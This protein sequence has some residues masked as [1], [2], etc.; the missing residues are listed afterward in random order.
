MS[1]D[2]SAV[3]WVAT[4]TALVVL[5]AV[6]LL[7]V[8]R[9]RGAVTAGGAGICIAI[10]S[11]LA[12]LAAL[13]MAMVLGQGTAGQFLACYVT[14][15]SLSADNLFVFMLVISRFSVP[16]GAVDYV[17]SIGIA[18]SLV[19][20]TAFIVAG[21][22]A[23]NAFDWVFYLFGGF[24]VYTAIRLLL[25]ARRGGAD[26]EDSEEMPPGVSLLARIL[27]TSQVYD[28]RRLTV[29]I[30]GRRMLTPILLVVSV[31]GVA[32]VVFALDSLPA[33]FG[34]TRSPFVI[35]TA[36]AFAMLGLRQLYYVVAGLLTRL[37][38]LPA[39]L[40][41]I[42]GFIGVKLIFEA[43]HGS[44]VDRV[45]PVP[46]PAIGVAVSLAVIVGTLLAATVASM[47][48][49]RIERGRAEPDGRV[50]SRAGTSPGE[51]QQESP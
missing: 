24:L 5:L 18:L 38:Y 11:G 20:R 26:G 12:L 42:L 51:E 9:R 17:L 47:V 33:A 16:A 14:E 8:S 25:P 45:G 6:D 15:Y 34:L 1:T 23:A 28:G 39:A 13:A 2:V 22:A 31:I 44:H 7:V 43:L 37:V 3:G 29:T 27:P 36:N 4:V 35:I 50:T 10:Y 41:V 32:N 21:S 40:A 46:V 19:L 30:A 48:R 49:K